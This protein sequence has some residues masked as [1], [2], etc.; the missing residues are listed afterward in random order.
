MRRRSGPNPSLRWLEISLATISRAI[1]HQH[2]NTRLSL[3]S[4]TR[5]RNTLHHKRRAV[6]VMRRRSGSRSIRRSCAIEDRRVER[7]NFV[8]GVVRVAVETTV[9]GAAATVVAVADHITVGTGRSSSENSSLV[10]PGGA[11]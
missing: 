3:L 6:G 10:W 4:G 9:E 2:R 7:P 1:I 8:V 11:K 5:R